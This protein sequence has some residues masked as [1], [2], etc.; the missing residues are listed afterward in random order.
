MRLSHSVG[1]G[2][3][4]PLSAISLV[5]RPGTA[6]GCHIWWVVGPSN[7]SLVPFWSLVHSASASATSPSVGAAFPHSPQLPCSAGG[8]LPAL[9]LAAS[10]SGSSS[11]DAVSTLA[12]PGQGGLPVEGVLPV[13]GGFFVQGVLPR[14]AFFMLSLSH[15]LRYLCGGCLGT[16]QQ[17]SCVLS[18]WPVPC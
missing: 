15:C 14:R 7:P 8:R 16:M 4:P 3:P 17:G 12:F 9:L 2:I 18:G 5:F 1:A 10:S 13:L 11:S 6:T